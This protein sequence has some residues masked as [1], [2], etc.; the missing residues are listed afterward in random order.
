MFYEYDYDNDDDNGDDN[1]DN[2]DDIGDNDKSVIV[3]C[4]YGSLCWGQIMIVT[5]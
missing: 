1:D 4:V 2:S 3:I 5:K